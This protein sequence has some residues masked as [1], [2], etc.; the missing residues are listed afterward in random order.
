MGYRFT[1]EKY[2]GTKSRYEC[3]VCNKPKVF[4]R[5]VET[6]TGLH[7]HETVG[8]CSRVNSC[9]YRKSPKEYFNENGI[10]KPNPVASFKAPQ[11][12]Q[13]KPKLSFI[14]PDLFK[15]SL[16]GYDRNK[17]VQF[18]KNTFGNERARETIERY[19]IGTSRYWQGSTIFWN[20]DINNRIR[21]GKIMLYDPATGKRL[22]EPFNH[23]TWVH[24]V[25]NKPD[26]KDHPK[27]F[28]EH[29]LKDKTRTV[30]IVESEKSAIICSLYKLDFIWLAVG[31]MG[32]LT[33]SNLEAVKGRKVILY[34]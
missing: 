13:A 24:K 4:T 3:P 10:E 8:I 27:L 32:N 14:D 21:T 26:L 34:P 33:A 15:Q 19:Y 30:A 9:G 12:K 22:K 29:L 23:I 11:V 5:Y 18:L 17:F 20:I 1:L 31:S 2:S 16:T 6:Q 7:I 28:G 25:I